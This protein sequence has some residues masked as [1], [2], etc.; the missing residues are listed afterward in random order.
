MSLLTSGSTSRFILQPG[1]NLV[2]STDGSST[3]SYFQAAYPIAGN[4]DIPAVNGVGVIA[5]PASSTI[6]LGPQSVI[7]RWVITQVSGMG[8]TAVQNV[9]QW[10][11]SVGAGPDVVHIHG[12]GAPSATTGANHA[13]VGSM[14]VDT[15]NAQVYLQAGTKSAPVWKLVTRAA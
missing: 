13:N 11:P 4:Q 1:E 10:V 7:T 9:A 12:A 8:V 3:C 5:V 6:T 14:Y 2:L 15:V